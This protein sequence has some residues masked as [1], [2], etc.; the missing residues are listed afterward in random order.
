MRR[1]KI[2]AVV[3]SNHVPNDG[4]AALYLHSTSQWINALKSLRDMLCGVVFILTN[5]NSE[6][7][8][9]SKD[10]RAVTSEKGI[11]MTHITHF[12]K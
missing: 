10:G 6:T 5:R 8:S 3:S 1:G 9:P 7:V 12:K 11:E 4:N 2:E